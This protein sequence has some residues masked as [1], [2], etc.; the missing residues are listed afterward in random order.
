[1]SENELLH[2]AVAADTEGSAHVTSSSVSDSTERSPPLQSSS[3]KT[4]SVSQQQS[5]LPPRLQKKQRQA[6]EENYMKYYKPMD[7]MRQSN[8]YHRKVA[9][10]TSQRHVDSGRQN[11][12]GSARRVRD[13]NFRG[14]VGS[15]PLWTDDVAAMSNGRSENVCG[16]SSEQSS[17]KMYFG[18]SSSGDA[19]LSDSAA[20]EQKPPV[21][22]LTNT[23]N[24][25]ASIEAGVASLNIQSTAASRMSQPSY[26]CPVSMAC[27]LCKC[28]LPCPHYEQ[29]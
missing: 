10:E 1:M 5:N 26:V 21:V 6:E 4:N 17:S 11:G 29:Q 2:V 12:T 7:Y 8:S 22:I 19:R 9:A 18:Q 14:S 25:Q 3:Q 27:G 28:E 16:D 24:K 13:V 23:T 15:R 20:G